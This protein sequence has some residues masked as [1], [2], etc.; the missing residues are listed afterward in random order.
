MPCYTE[1]FQRK[2]ADQP[3]NQPIKNELIE[4]NNNKNNKNRTTYTSSFLQHLELSPHGPSFSL[5][6]TYFMNICRSTLPSMKYCCLK[7]TLILSIFRIILQLTSLHLNFIMI[8]FLE[9]SRM[10]S[11]FYCSI[12]TCTQPILSG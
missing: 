8:S 3:T 4:I 12:P 6:S 11:N 1:L 5:F 9:C 7:L 2:P 10:S